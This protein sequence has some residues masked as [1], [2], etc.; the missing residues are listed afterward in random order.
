VL[1]RSLIAISALLCGCSVLANPRDGLRF[2]DENGTLAI[3]P[4]NGELEGVQP[5]FRWELV[6]GADRYQI[7]LS[8]ECTSAEPRSC[9]FDGAMRAQTDQSL[10]QPPA[11]LEVTRY[12]WHVRPCDASGCGDWSPIRYLDVGR[13][14]SDL[15]GDGSGDIAV[16]DW[17]RVHVFHRDASGWSVYPIDSATAATPMQFGNVLEYAGDVNG[18]GRSELAIGA[19]LQWQHDVTDLGAGVWVDTPA[20]AGPLFGQTGIASCDIDGDGYS[21]LFVGA[22]DRVGPYMAA[23]RV[24]VFRGQAGE[25][26]AAPFAIESTLPA[27]AGYFGGSP[28][29]HGLGCTDLDGDG[30]SDLLVGAPFEGPRGQVHVYRGS[31]AFRGTDTPLV[32]VGTTVSE[33]IGRLIRT[34]DFDGDGFGDAVI[35][36]DDPVV[37]RGARTLQPTFSALVAPDF[38]TIVS[39]T[40]ADFDGDGFDD[41]AYVA[42]TPELTSTVVV[43]LGSEVGLGGLLPV[44]ELPGVPQVGAIGDTD[45]DGDSELAVVSGMPPGSLRVLSITPMRSWD[46]EI[47]EISSVSQMRFGISIAGL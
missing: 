13:Q 39:S 3:S 34:G 23:G 25:T 38:T 30:Y 43:H 45:G 6:D 5:V 8:S 35:F 46:E 21:D 16:G 28:K 4:A 40:S 7:E 15:D 19:T 10:W 33:R 37:V 20:G 24:Y 31:P 42:G 36:G 47:L 17:N 41:I 29:Q 27:Q 22:D 26:L 1:V 18:D 2:A 44:I 11:A 14:R 32:I 12:V 9:T